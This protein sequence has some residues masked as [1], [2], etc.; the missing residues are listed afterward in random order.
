M[1]IPVQ[2]AGEGVSHPLFLT[3][4]N[5]AGLT[6]SREEHLNARML[7]PWAGGK[8]VRGL[9]N[10]GVEFVF[11]VLFLSIFVGTNHHVRHTLAGWACV[12]YRHDMRWKVDEAERVA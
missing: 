2:D 6:N 12:L 5:A 1:R 8:A 7:K 9:Y 11:L 3:P 4:R 10:F